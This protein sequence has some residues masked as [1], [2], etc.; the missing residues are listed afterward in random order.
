LVDRLQ[1][2]SN[3]QT[4]FADLLEL[5]TLLGELVFDRNGFRGRGA[6]RDSRDERL[7]SL[8]NGACDELRTLGS[9]VEPLVCAVGRLAGVMAVAGVVGFFWAVVAADMID[10]GFVTGV[11]EKVAGV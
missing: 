2:L 11:F 6:W 8:S 5:L 9:D 10:L 4:A 1:F 7:G 3:I